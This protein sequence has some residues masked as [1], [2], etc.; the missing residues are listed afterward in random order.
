MQCTESLCE[1]FFRC[2][3]ST[4]GSDFYNIYEHTL[5]HEAALL[6]TGLY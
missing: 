1:F 4:F 3:D 5:I 6:D 2:F